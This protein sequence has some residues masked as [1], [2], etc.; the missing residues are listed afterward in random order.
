MKAVKKITALA[1]MVCLS[2]TCFASKVYAADGGVHFSDPT[3]QVG[4]TVEV[5]CNI[6]STVGNLASIEVDLAYDTESLTYQSGDEGVTDNGDGTLSYT[7]TG[8]SSEETFKVEFQAA[9]E[10]T[11]VVNIESVTATS[12]DGSVLEMTRGTSTVTIEEGD[13]SKVSDTPVSNNPDV[14][15]DVNGVTYKLSDNFSDE[16]IPAGFTETKVEYEGAPRRMVTQESSG[17]VLGY[18]TSGEDNGEFFVYHSDNATFMP[19]E[20]VIISDLTS[21]VLLSGDESVSMPEQYQTATLTLNGNDFTV[22]QDTTKDGYYVVN[23]INSEGKE[24]YYQYDSVE[25][26]YQRTEI[27]ETETPKSADSGNA[28]V[29]KLFSFIKDYFM[30]VAIVSA[31]L[32][33]L[34]LIIIIVLAVKLHHRNQE[35]DDLYDEYGIDEEEG[36]TPVV[37]EPKAKKKAARREEEEDL[38]DLNEEEDELEDD[39]N[40]E[41]DD[42]DLEDETYDDADEE[43]DT[44]D[45]VDYWENREEL[46]DDDS[47][48]DDL[49][50]LLNAR[51]KKPAKRTKKPARKLSHAEDDDTFKMDIIDLD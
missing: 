50:E 6:N 41:F 28:P 36:E 32:A 13:P 24:G 9:K 39:F 46:F 23:A 34:V 29:D 43:E 11:S 15:V 26:T 48:I 8:G 25:G 31:V 3:T 2:I 51:I 5:E 27:G 33:L 45:E 47:E 10:G 44:E 14:D 19:F 7:G 37:R 30:I 40:E 18:L 12:E 4:E 49:D 20:Q 38:L 1:A 35:L 21:I 42:E 22:W 17:I 16:D